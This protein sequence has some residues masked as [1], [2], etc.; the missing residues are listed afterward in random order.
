MLL[1]VFQL[2]GDRYALD[3]AAVNEVLPF[4]AVRPIPLAPEGI[5]GVFDYRG[6]PV[7]VVDLSA[8]T[9][10]RRAERNL[11]TRIVVV[12]YPDG[13]GETRHLGVIAEKATQTIRREAGDFSDAGVRS[14]G[15]AYLGP[16]TRDDA[17]LVQRVDVTR[18]LPASVR[19]A[20]FR[21]DVD[22]PWPLATS[23]AS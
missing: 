15:G 10:G 1:L 23:N 22:Q 14:D 16:V 3:V 11:S 5:A 8:L 12:N 6:T 21:R 9:L 19:D 17:G 4:V 18:L 7:P 2:G 20:L 13:A